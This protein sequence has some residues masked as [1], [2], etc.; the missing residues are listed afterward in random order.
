[1]A[2]KR[3]TNPVSITIAAANNLASCIAT[4]S[5]MHILAGGATRRQAFDHMKNA[6]PGLAHNILENAARKLFADDPKTTQEKAREDNPELLAFDISEDVLVDDPDWEAELRE[7][8]PPGY[9]DMKDA[10]GGE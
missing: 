10:F 3:G 2:Q 8:A 9:N 1:M 7:M 6:W 5:L 4:A